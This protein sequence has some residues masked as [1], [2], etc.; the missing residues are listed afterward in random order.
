MENVIVGFSERGK[1]E[2]FRDIIVKSGFVNTEVCSSGDEVLRRAN[3]FAGGLVLCGYKI[4]G[5]LYNEIY[6]LLPEGFEMLVLL[7]GKQAGLV[8]EDD[9][10]SLVLPVSKSELIRT[11]SMIVDFSEGRVA[12]KTKNAVSARS[13]RDKILIEKAKLMLMNNFNITEDAAHRFIQK[14]SMNKGLKMAETAE[15]IL[16]GGKL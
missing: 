12:A 9:I 11:V 14:N 15:I 10:F 3:Q 6:E 13:E 16:F 2:A 8:D 7:S 4:G 5:M 1:G